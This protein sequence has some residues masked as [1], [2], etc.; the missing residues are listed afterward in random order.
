MAVHGFI[1][2]DVEIIRVAVQFP[3]AG[4]GRMIE[5]ARFA[6]GDDVELAHLLAEARRL[7]APLAADEVIGAVVQEVHRD[8]REQLRSAALHEEHV[9][10][11]ADAQ[12]LLAPSN[13]LI[14]DGVKFLSAMRNF[15]DAKTFALIIEQSLCG[16]FQSLG[17]Q[18]GGAGTEIENS[19]RHKC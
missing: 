5:V 15:R 10:R 13:C 9:M 2:A 18:H 1:R 6:G 19:M 11:I 3:F 17:R 7:L 16:F 12:Q 8:D 4:C 14:G